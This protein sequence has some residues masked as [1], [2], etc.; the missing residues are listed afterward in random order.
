MS[1][2]DGHVS[3]RASNNLSV[4]K[5]LLVLY[6]ANSI[7]E[8]SSQ[9]CVIVKNVRSAYKQMTDVS[10][11][12]CLHTWVMFHSPVGNIWQVRGKW[13]HNARVCSTDESRCLCFW[14]GSAKYARCVYSRLRA[15][16]VWKLE[17]MLKWLAKIR[18]YRSRVALLLYSRWL[19]W[20]N[21]SL[22]CVNYSPQARS[23]FF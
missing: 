4:E 19:I 14:K 11:L 9:R 18:R 7:I 22:N 6:N 8:H 1:F 23:N 10:M 16:W 2:A 20:L 21:W 13:S 5:S 17:D 12:P 15:H 3:R